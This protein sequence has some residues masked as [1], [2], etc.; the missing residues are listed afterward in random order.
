MFYTVTNKGILNTL[1][2]NEFS[3]FILYFLKNIYLTF[4]DEL[5]PQRKANR[6]RNLA[7]KVK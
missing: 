6:P 2:L 4:M 1:K 5:E 7:F 3:K